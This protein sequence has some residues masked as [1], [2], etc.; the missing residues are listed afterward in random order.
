MI[1]RTAGSDWQLIAQSDHA[2]L[3][4]ELASHVGNQLFDRPAERELFIQAVAIHDDGWI[5]VDANS[6][7]N[8]R[9]EPMDFTE[10]PLS[11]ALTAWGTSA[12]RATEIHPLVGLLV[13]LHSL[14]LSTVRSSSESSTLSDASV[15]F[16]LNKFQ[17][18]QIELQELCRNT[19]KLS[20]DQPLHHG[21]AESSVDPREQS[22]VHQFRLLQAM[23]RLSLSLC[24][25]GPMETQ[26]KPVVARPG[27]RPIT[28]RSQRTSAAG[29]VV[30][31]WPMAS[32][33]IGCSVAARKI[34]ASAFA[35]PSQLAGAVAAATLESMQ[36]TVAASR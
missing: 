12:E 1:R 33:V 11:L 24:C 27:G 34:A 20:A 15:R 25:S 32:S 29:L 17:H 28:L 10:A 9:G 8:G 16:A 31:P 13:S 21:I 5:D 30:K 7:L 36:F 23:D 3:A 35:E 26:I 6:P 19:L 14:A 4:A 2:R 22:I 18:R